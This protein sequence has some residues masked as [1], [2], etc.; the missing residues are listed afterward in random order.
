[1]TSGAVGH[2]VDAADAA[3]AGL[4]DELDRAAGLPAVGRAGHRRQGRDPA[5]A[6][7]PWATSSASVSPAEAIAGLVNV[8]R[9]RAARR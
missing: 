2:E 1:M 7:H 6:R 4:G 3:G 9:G 5:V 8:T